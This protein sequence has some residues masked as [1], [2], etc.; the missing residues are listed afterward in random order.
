MSTARRVIGPRTRPDGDGLIGAPPRRLP[1]PYVVPLAVGRRQREQRAQ[2]S[3]APGAHTARCADAD[4]RA[5][6]QHRGKCGIRRPPTPRNPGTCA[7]ARPA[8]APE[9]A[10][11]ARAAPPARACAPVL[12]PTVPTRAVRTDEAGVHPPGNAP[13]RSSPHPA[14]EVWRDRPPVGRA[15]SRVWLEER[16]HIRVIPEVFF[17]T[18]GIRGARRHLLSGVRA[19]CAHRADTA[20]LPWRAVCDL[21]GGGS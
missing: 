2:P 18:S 14:G 19:H 12:G 3:R 21:W 1:K 8:P 20:H 10:P 5:M 4:P 15:P 7:N 6:Q 17:A 11:S 13:P 16:R 9:P